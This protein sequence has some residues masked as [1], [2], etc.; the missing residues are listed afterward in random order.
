MSYS[1]YIMLIYDYT[2]LYV[3]YSKNGHWNISGLYVCVL[4]R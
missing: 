3:I 1:F 4:L 2:S